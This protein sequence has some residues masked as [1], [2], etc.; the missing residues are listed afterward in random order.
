MISMDK[1]TSMWQRG[2]NTDQSTFRTGIDQAM[3]LM[4]GLIA[5]NDEL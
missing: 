5:K 2:T 4:Q 1:G 3:A